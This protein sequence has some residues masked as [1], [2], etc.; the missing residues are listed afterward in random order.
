MNYKKKNILAVNFEPN[1][2]IH[3]N[4]AIRSILI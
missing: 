2:P 1:D 4:K 3:K